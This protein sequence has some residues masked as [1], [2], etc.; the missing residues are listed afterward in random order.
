MNYDEAIKALYY[1]QDV[2]VEHIKPTDEEKAL[3]LKTLLS[4]IETA[5]KEHEL[6]MAYKELHRL[7]HLDELKISVYTYDDIKTTEYKITELER[8]L[9]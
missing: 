7:E 5:K 4:F 3:R 9:K 8:E 6:L 2:C 1:L